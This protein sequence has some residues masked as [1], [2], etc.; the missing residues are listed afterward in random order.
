MT[1]ERALEKVA[2]PFLLGN[3]RFLAGYRRTDS[4]HTS[5]RHPWDSTAFLVHAN[6][7]TTTGLVRCRRGFTSTT[8]GTWLHVDHNRAIVC[9]QEVIRNVFA[10][11]AFNTRNQEERLRNNVRHRRVEVS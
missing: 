1:S 8:T 7:R 9:D 10:L 2:P 5:Y 6:V 3:V 4:L 11:L